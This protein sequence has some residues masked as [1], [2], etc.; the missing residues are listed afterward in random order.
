MSI[1]SMFSGIAG[2]YDI[3]NDILSLGVHRLWKRTLANYAKRRHFEKALDI[4]TGT[5]DMIPILLGRASEVVGIDFCRPMLEAGQG[6]REVRG[7]VIQADA[8]KLPFAS[9][10]FDLITVTFG[11]RNIPELDHALSEMKRVLKDDG[12]LLVLEFGQPGT[13]PFSLLYKCYSRW[14]LPMVGGL[15]SGDRS[16]YRYLCE[17]SEKFPC[18]DRFGLVLENAGFRVLRV[19][20]LFMGIAYVYAC[21]RPR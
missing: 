6:K 15:L 8:L 14:I 10:S 21:V 2:K 18:G 4:C 11:V 16:A 12:E 9:S 5:G 19:K 7:R 17:T 1:N 13:F 20:S 3:A